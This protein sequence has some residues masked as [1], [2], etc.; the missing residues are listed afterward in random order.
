MSTETKVAAI[1]DSFKKELARDRSAMSEHSRFMIENT[2]ACDFNVFVT[3]FR[4][5]L[6]DMGLS[7]ERIFIDMPGVK[8]I[9]PEPVTA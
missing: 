3:W 2:L 1:Y 5:E 6:T 8:I 7:T 9:E 4:E